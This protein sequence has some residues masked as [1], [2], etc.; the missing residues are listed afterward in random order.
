MA[1]PLHA[2]VLMGIGALR[3]YYPTAES[4]VAEPKVEASPT[5]VVVEQPVVQPA[6]EGKPRG[7]P[8]KLEQ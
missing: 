1:L 7:R 8:K 2:E 3:R 6:K 5:E 4:A